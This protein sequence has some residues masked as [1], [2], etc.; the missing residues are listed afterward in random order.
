MELVVSRIMEEA[1]SDP[2]LEFLVYDDFVK[3]QYVSYIM[4]PHKIDD[5]LCVVNP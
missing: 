5:D 4:S 3:V 2:S 1:S